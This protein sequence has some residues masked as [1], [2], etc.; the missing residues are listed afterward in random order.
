VV[1]PEE[2]LDLRRQVTQ[3]LEDPARLE[4]MAT[5]MRALAR[6]DAAEAI[7]EELMALARG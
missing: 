7:A 5:A 3:L 4:S 1:V 2:Q 6:P